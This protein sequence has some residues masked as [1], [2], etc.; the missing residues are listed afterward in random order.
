MP[1]NVK[2]AIFIMLFC[3]TIL[4]LMVFGL[5]KTLDEI[6]AEKNNQYQ[7]QLEAVSEEIGVD[8]KNILPLETKY[9]DT[10]RF[11]TDSAEYLIKFDKENKIKAIVKDSE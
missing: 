7:E 10:K 1:E 2:G 8:P 11:K 9:E 3:F 6:A 5:S 4:G